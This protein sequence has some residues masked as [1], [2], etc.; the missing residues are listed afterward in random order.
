MRGRDPVSSPEEHS[1]SITS[2]QMF[3]NR[4]MSPANKISS[5]EVA[6]RQLTI[7][8]IDGLSESA[9][10]YEA[11]ERAE[12][13]NRL[14]ELES[15][16]ASYENIERQRA[17]AWREAAH[18]LRGNL[19][20]VKTATALLNN[21]GTTD[22][23]R[24]K[25]LS[26]LHRGVE[27]MHE[28]LNELISLARLEAGREVRELRAFDIGD[29]CTQLCDSMHQMAEG[30]GLQLTYDGPRSFDVQGDPMKVRR[31][32]QNL[33]V[34]ALTYTNRGKVIVAISETAEDRW[35]LRVEDT[36]PGVPASVT[37]AVINN[38]DAP[39]AVILNGPGAP[40]AA[41]GPTHLRSSRAGGE[42]I[43]LSIVKRLCD[44]LDAT[45]QLAPRPG[46]GS[47]FTVTFPR[48]YQGVEP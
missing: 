31:I 16:L 1:R 19:G 4:V 11:M 15:A 5:G 29:V 46:G 43:G 18:D 7:L 2:R 14:S 22:F 30:R 42:G 36:G 38:P 9:E 23:A 28:L 12:A 17:D 37:G 45:L 47:I 25:S 27:S 40:A 20:V 35:V 24:T 41:N 33:L 13:Q 34:N 26:I 44:L 6:R 39:R 3:Q 48:T 21:G 8:C 10:R 32:A